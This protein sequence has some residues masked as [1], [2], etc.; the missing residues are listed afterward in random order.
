M[1]AGIQSNCKPGGAVSASTS[2]LV[3]TVLSSVIFGCAMEH[4][5]VD[6][7]SSTPIPPIESE[8]LFVV[9]GGSNSLSVVNSETN[10][11]VGTILLKNAA[12]P[13]HVYLSPDR[14]RLA[15]AIP[16]IDLS[17]GHDAGGHGGHGMVGAILIMDANTGETKASRRFDNS[18]HNAAFSPDGKEVWT[19]QMA[20]PGKIL[21]LDAASLATKETIDVGDGPAE[22]TFSVDGKYAFAANGGSNSVTVID[23]ATKGIVKTITVGNNPVGAWPGKDTIMYVDNEGSKTITAIHGSSLEIVRTY[24][25][26]FTPGM[27]ATSPEGELWVTDSDS[28]RVAVYPAGSTDKAAQIAVGPGAHGIAFSRDGKSAYISNQSAGT[29]S[30]IDVEIHSVKKTLTVGD[31]PNGMVIR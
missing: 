5:M 6:D 12:Y 4:G 15:L 27:A 19:S 3:G 17:E 23:G 24:A 1:N 26:G 18:N 22:V 9:N 2:I 7:P 21:V 30:V 28:G 11:V 29:V 10:E 13:H 20:T 16:G 8:A 25:L 31:K 14:T